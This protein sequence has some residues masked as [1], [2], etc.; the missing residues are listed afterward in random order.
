[1]LPHHAVSRMVFRLTRVQCPRVVPAAIRLFAKI[2]K[3]NLAEAEY[4]NP[5][6]YQ[7]FN[8]FLRAVSKQVLGLYKVGKSTWSAP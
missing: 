3:V 5:E 7:T 6:D 1:M 2:F 4:T 8:Q